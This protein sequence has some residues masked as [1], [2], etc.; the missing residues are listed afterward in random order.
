MKRIIHGVTYN[1]DTARIVARWEYND[2]DGYPTDA[3]LYQTR[4]GAFFTV[5]KWEVDG[6]EKVYFEAVSRDEVLR[7]VERTNNLEIID[8]S[9]LQDPPEAAAE[10]APGATL[11]IRVPASL[12]DQLEELAQD[13]GVSLNTWMMRCA[14]RCTVLEEVEACLGG[15]LSTGMALNS[16]PEPGA[17]S[18]SA[19]ESM[20]YH[21]NEEAEKAAAI[22]GWRGADKL[23]ELATAAAGTEH[24]QSF[25]LYEKDD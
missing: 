2:Q 1:T 4:G 7:L 5:H 9:V 16:E 25:P 11:Y 19:I 18:K 8:D 15:I 13:A 23:R 22:L 21:M 6:K 14:E 17:Y 12:K 10:A 24:Y 3:T 20:V